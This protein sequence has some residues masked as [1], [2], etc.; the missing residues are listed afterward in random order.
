MR[1]K[2]K[3][4][5]WGYK[6]T[7]HAKFPKNQNFL[8]P[9]KRVRIEGVRN[10]RFFGKLGVLCFARFFLRFTF[11]PYYRRNGKTGTKWGKNC[12]HCTIIPFSIDSLYFLEYIFFP[13]HWLVSKRY[14][15]DT[16]NQN[17]KQSFSEM[18]FFVH[19]LRR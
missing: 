5:N 15:M 19:F 2:G 16:F 14:Q 7:K 11:L 9:N 6:K 12:T 10:F 17:C 13:V 3:S 18:P 8:P 4:Q 1:Q